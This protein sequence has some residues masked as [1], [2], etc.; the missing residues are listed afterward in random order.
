MAPERSPTEWIHE[1]VKGNPV[2]V[3]EFW[4]SYAPRLQQ[5]ASRQMS[6]ALLRRIGADDVVQSVCRSFFR[7][8]EELEIAEREADGLW[9]LLC[10][11]TLHKVR[12]HARFH[13]RH[14]R[15]ISREAELA[16]RA[17][18][19][20]LEDLAIASGPTPEQTL[21]FAEQLQGL[22]DSL[23]ENE[24][25]FVELKLDGLPQEEI[26]AQMGCSDRTVRRYQERVRARWEKELGLP[27][28]SPTSDTL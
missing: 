20:T 23:D 16:G 1:L 18:E 3:Q 11:M 19:S 5:L 15:D 28:Q 21:V 17:D 2:V 13:R 4:D 22:L 27:L 26:A 8:I 12:R 24:K 9:R 10:A 7:R 14:K 25:T 6:P